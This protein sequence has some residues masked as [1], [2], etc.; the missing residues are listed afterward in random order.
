[1]NLDSTFSARE[2]L[3]AILSREANARTKAWGVVVTRVDVR[4]IQ[5]SPE[6]LKSMELQIAAERKKRAA[7]LESEGQRTS[8]VNAAKAE[9]TTRLLAAD[10]EQRRLVAEARGI[11]TA[12]DLVA[13]ALAGGGDDTDQSRGRAAD[14]LLDRQLLAAHEALAQSPNTKVLSL[15]S[16]SRTTI[17]RKRHQPLVPQPRRPPKRKGA[18]HRTPKKT[19]GG[20]PADAYTGIVDAAVAAAAA[21]Q[22]T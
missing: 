4:D 11:A 2:Q 20:P 9:R 7:V 13:R 21:V 22:D 5:P 19:A 18:I 10:A 15:A 8:A 12:L 1:M 14:L 3:N 6:I 17:H 16:P